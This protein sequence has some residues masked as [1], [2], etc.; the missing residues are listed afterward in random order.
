MVTNQMKM[1]VGTF[2]LIEHFPVAGGVLRFPVLQMEH[3]QE[4]SWMC[5]THG[6]DCQDSAGPPVDNHESLAFDILPCQVTRFFHNEIMLFY[7]SLRYNSYATQSTHLKSIVQCFL[8]TE[9]C[10]HHHSQF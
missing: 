1:L 7:S 10:N 3:F 9:L 8:F 5:W 6:D 4:M 2:L